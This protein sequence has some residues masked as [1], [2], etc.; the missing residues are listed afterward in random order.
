MFNISLVLFLQKI[1]LNTNA[2]SY[3][4]YNFKKEE[5]INKK[6]MLTQR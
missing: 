5:K 3:P 1:L 2:N 6:A 4:N